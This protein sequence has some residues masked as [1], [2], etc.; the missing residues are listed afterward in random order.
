MFVLHVTGGFGV[1]GIIPGWYNMAVES[2]WL[3]FYV[4]WVRLDGSVRL[5]D[6]TVIDG[7]CR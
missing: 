2:C 5:P 1:S 4:S 6:F 3:V 7:N